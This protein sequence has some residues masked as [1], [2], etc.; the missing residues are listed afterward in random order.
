M[1]IFLNHLFKE[2]PFIASF[3]AGLLSFLSPCVLPLVP[4]YMSYISGSDLKI[5]KNTQIKI[6]ILPQAILFVLGFSL[7]FVLLGASM[8]KIINIFTP[9][10]IKQASGIII[11]IFGFHFLGIFHLKFL[12][13]NKTFWIKQNK[14]FH[15]YLTPLILGISFSLGWTPCIGPIFT[16]IIFLGGY[17]EG[18]SLSLM[19]IFALGLSLPFL[20]VALLVQKALKFIGGLKK[21]LRKVEI[22]CGILLIVLG[23]GMLTGI[24]DKIAV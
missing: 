1:D 19:I 22:I 13:Q 6:N 18:Y 9:Y 20:L 8:A 12:Y 15:Q 5:L 21:H 10:W 14:N 23:L 2:A 24:L 4:A 7:V 17:Q 3:L 11:I 16:S